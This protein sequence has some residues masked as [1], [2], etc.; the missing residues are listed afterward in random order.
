MEWRFMGAWSTRIFDTDT[1]MDILS[2]YKKLLGYGMKPDEVYEKI[3]DYFGGDFIGKDDEDDYWLAIVYFQWKNGILVDE[4][5][6]NA[7]RCIEDARFLERWQESGKA[8]YEKRKKTLEEFKYNL[9]YV[10]NETKKKFP[11]PK[12]VR[13]TKYK[14]G[15]ILVYKMSRLTNNTKEELYRRVKESSE[16]NKGKYVAFQV[17]EIKKE[18]ISRVCPDLD[19]DI[20]PI[21]AF[22]DWIG[23]QKP[24]MED[25]I[26]VNYRYFIE[27]AYWVEY[28]FETMEKLDK[29]YLEK[30]ICSCFKLDDIE[31]L[32]DKELHEIETI[33][34]IEVNMEDYN[35]LNK[36]Y[37]NMIV[38]SGMDMPLIFSLANYDNL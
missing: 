21:L 10:K 38:F 25:L 24:R 11:K 13:K 35:E 4:V 18:S 12:G 27:R 31:Q 26:N 30:R 23:D 36:Q 29:P 1:A 2:E 5:K 19:Y 32:G 20:C 3:S 6:E 7:L 14:V 9:V 33:G 28:N 17:V 8:N 22:I 34:N 37:P 16:K 15:D